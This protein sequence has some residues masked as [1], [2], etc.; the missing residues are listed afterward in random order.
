MTPGYTNGVIVVNVDG[1]GYVGFYVEN[2]ND[3]TL[4]KYIED[5]WKQDATGMT[6]EAAETQLMLAR[7][8]IKQQ[9]YQTGPIEAKTRKEWCVEVLGTDPELYDRSEQE[10]LDAQTEYDKFDEEFHQREDN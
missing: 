1:V 8:D 9:G 10:T 7:A 5:N 6:L 4:P 3:D 2:G